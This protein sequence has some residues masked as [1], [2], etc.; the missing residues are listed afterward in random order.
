VSIFGTFEGRFESFSPEQQS[1]FYG[2]FEMLNRGDL[3]TAAKKFK[4]LSGQV[5]KI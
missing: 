4:E 2:A 1:L 5:K 3:A